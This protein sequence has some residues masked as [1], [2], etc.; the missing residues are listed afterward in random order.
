MKSCPGCTIWVTKVRR[1]QWRVV[2]EFE[3]HLEASRTVELPAIHKEWESKAIQYF[4]AGMRALGSSYPE[5]D[6]ALVLAT[7][8]GLQIG[9]LADPTPNVERT[10]LEPLL[11]RLV[12][13]LASRRGDQGARSRKR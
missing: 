13:A 11:R 8:T 9:E 6:A 3:M 2:A 1:E 12:Y 10:L 5:V 4:T 7:I